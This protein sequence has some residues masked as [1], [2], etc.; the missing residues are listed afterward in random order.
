MSP[1]GAESLRLIVREAPQIIPEPPRPLIREL[2]PADVFPVDAL[3]D[4]LGA[5]TRAIHE[6]VQAPMAICGQSTLGAATLAA[7]AHADVELPTGQV[8]PISNFFVSVAATGERK[9]ATDSEA[10]R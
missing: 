2:P 7:Q 8:K 9:T 4:V 5:A 3:G 1:D 10:L 6:R